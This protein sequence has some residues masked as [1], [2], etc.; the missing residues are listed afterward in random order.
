[1]E[2][3]RQWDDRSAGRKRLLANKE[4]VGQERDCWPIIILHTENQPSEVKDKSRYS[5]INKN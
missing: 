4:T 3:R 2:A 5:E 1:M